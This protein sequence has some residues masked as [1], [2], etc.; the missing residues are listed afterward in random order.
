MSKVAEITYGLDL[1]SQ[2][3]RGVLTSASKQAFIENM[4]LYRDGTLGVRP[5]L[6]HDATR[7][8]EFPTALPEEYHGIV[9][10]IKDTLIHVTSDA[11]DKLVVN[12]VSYG[13]AAADV[14]STYPVVGISTLP[15]YRVGKNRISN[16]LMALGQQQV[17][18]VLNSFGNFSNLVQ[19]AITHADFV[20]NAGVVHQGRLFTWSG[21]VVYFSDAY[22]YVTGTSAAQSFQV[23]SDVLGLWSIDSALLICGYDGRWYTLLGRG[24]PEDGTLQ[25]LGQSRAPRDQVEVVVVD[26]VLFFIS[27]D[28]VCVMSGQGMDDRTLTHLVDV[29]IFESKVVASSTHNDIHLAHAPAIDTVHA[30]QFVEDT[31]TN[32]TYEGDV[33]DWSMSPESGVLYGVSTGEAASTNFASQV[34]KRDMQL[35]RPSGASDINSAK[36]E[37]LADP[38]GVVTLS[39]VAGRV[40]LPRVH[41]PHKGYVR[42]R[43]IQLDVRYWKATTEYQDVACTVK[44]L[45]G[46]NAE[47]PVTLDLVHAD[48]AAAEGGFLRIEG[49]FPETAYTHLFEIHIE[50]I[51][52][53]AIE[54]VHVQYEMNDRNTI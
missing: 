47:T 49:R 26:G 46:N 19:T 7:S 29:A 38:D 23:D 50:G 39:T 27:N 5:W 52:S 42:A 24:N 22:D 16:S 18:V 44:V 17:E 4:Q 11:T 37:E 20:G 15:E 32:V 31:W 36:Q 2:G 10:M 14:P 21:N 13:T 45:D 8:H 28:H 25:S 33:E 12:G 51:Q 9:C 41:A 40:L 53:M 30:V 6:K 35:N 1:W 54:E 34:L 43:G 3:T 48:L